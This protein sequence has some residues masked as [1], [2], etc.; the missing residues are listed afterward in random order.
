SKKEEKKI[1]KTIKKEIVT[2]SDCLPWKSLLYF[3]TNTNQILWIHAYIP[4]SPSPEEWKFV[5]KESG[6]S[7]QELCKQTLEIK[8]MNWEEIEMESQSLGSST[9]TIKMWF[10]NKKYME[11]KS[12]VPNFI[13]NLK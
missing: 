10:I 1:L 13:Q 5:L 12:F 9:L 6:K 11:T 2:N 3:Q 7:L 8:W 4:N